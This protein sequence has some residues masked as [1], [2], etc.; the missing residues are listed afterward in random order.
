MAKGEGGNAIDVVEALMGHEGYLTGAY[1]R[2]TIQELEAFY[3]K[4][5]HLLWIYRTK[6]INEGELRQL[7]QENRVLQGEL[8]NIKQ[9]IA[10]MNAMQNSITPDALQEM[11]DSRLRALQ[12]NEE[13]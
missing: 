3:R 10:L 2:L 11:I 6:P 7:E 9:Q 13:T 5:E 1:V 12:E 4:N 8:T